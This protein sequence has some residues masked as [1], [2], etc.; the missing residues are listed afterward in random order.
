MCSS[1]GQLTF[2]LETQAELHGRFKSCTLACISS[3]RK[4][5]QPSLCT[6]MYMNAD[7]HTFPRLRPDQFQDKQE[8]E[9]QV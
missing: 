1:V 5:Q 7:A 9:Q 2:C 3:G 4:Q 6:A 8:P